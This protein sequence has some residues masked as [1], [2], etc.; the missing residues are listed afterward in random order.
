VS[1]TVLHPERESLHYP[2]DDSDVKITPG[3]RAYLLAFDN[4]LHTVWK[5]GDLGDGRQA[6]GAT[7]MK[8]ACFAALTD[9][10]ELIRDRTC[11]GC[12]NSMGE[13]NAR[14]KLCKPC[15]KDH[16]LELNHARR[17]AKEQ[18]EAK[19][20]SIWKPPIT[21]RCLDCSEPVPTGR[22]R[23]RSYCTKCRPVRPRK[24]AA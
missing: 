16:T 9:G 1:V 19:A 10:M 20:K 24:K 3:M 7:Q 21:G 4:W 14:S 18:A 6:D 23:P 17:Q 5:Q 11:P 15:S 12:G 13:G 8:D 22:G 2:P